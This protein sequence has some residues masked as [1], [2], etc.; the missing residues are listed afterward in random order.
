M[1]KTNSKQA[2]QNIKNYIM[3]VFNEYATDCGSSPE[4]AA[5]TLAD[6][7]GVIFQDVKRVLNI[8]HNNYVSQADF[9]RYAAM[10]P[11]YVETFYNAWNVLA[12]ILEETP[13]EAAKYD[14]IKAE[15]VLTAIVYRELFNAVLRP[16][17]AK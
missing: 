2:K 4:K 14:N 8:K 3:A 16:Y 17:D 6:A 1:L 15:N 11:G 7:A 12:E 10:L 13:A 9:T 5:A